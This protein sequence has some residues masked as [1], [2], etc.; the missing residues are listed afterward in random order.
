MA[1]PGRPAPETSIVS[2]GSSV[3]LAGEGGLRPVRAPLHSPRGLILVVPPHIGF[4]G[5]A[6]PWTLSELS[7]TSSLGS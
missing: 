1:L 7:F 5:K 6:S 3:L 4:V 2:L